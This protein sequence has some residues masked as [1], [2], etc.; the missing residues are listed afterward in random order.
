M[1]QLCK[2]LVSLRVR[3]EISVVQMV[4]IVVQ[5]TGLAKVMQKKESAE[6]PRIHNK[7][8]QDGLPVILFVSSPPAISDQLV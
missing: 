4:A 2:A 7:Q 3:T 8:E 6:V 1:N 5:T